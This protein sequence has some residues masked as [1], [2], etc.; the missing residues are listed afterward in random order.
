MTLN[1]K[2]ALIT[3][4]TGG[5]G[6][7]IVDCLAKNGINTVYFTAFHKVNEAADF[8]ESIKKQFSIE[9]AWYKCDISKYAEVESVVNTIIAQSGKIDIL[10]NNAGVIKNKFWMYVSEEE[11][12]SVIDVNLKGSFNCIK[13]VS[14]HM[15]R[16]KYGRIVNISSLAGIAGGT[17]Q[18]AYS[19]SKA[20][21]LGLTATAVREF[22]RYNIKAFSIIP[23]MVETDLT[24]NFSENEK[25]KLLELIPMGRFARPE[26]IADAVWFLIS[27]CVNLKNGLQLIVDGGLHLTY[28]E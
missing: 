21:M 8:S 23:G 10:I 1:G 14:R 20:G 2:V 25:S 27:D 26:E 24:K 11:W 12:D 9:C 18:V 6:Q 28:E 7:K 4:G 13:A 22:S 16:N 19:A 17:G 5:I 3:G 15:V